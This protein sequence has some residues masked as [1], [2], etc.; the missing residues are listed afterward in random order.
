[1]YSERIV[2]HVDIIARI[3]GFVRIPPPDYPSFAIQI[4]RIAL[5]GLLIRT[6]EAAGWLYE[7]ESREETSFHEK[8]RNGIFRYAIRQISWIHDS[9]YFG[10]VDHSIGCGR[11]RSRQWALAADATTETIR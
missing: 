10:S 3:E 2:T 11:Q 5:Q 8:L 4:R 1:M 6:R 7:S 9:R